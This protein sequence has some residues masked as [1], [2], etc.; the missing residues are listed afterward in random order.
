VASVLF[1]LVALGHVARLVMGWK[2]I[3]GDWT[4]PMW[5]SV[6]VIVVC[7]GLSVGMWMCS[8]CKGQCDTAV[9]PQPKA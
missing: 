9:P 7:V 6:A 4:M 1:L 3:V 5:L 8:C 2:V